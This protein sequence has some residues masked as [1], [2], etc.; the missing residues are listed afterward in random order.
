MPSP[1]PLV[2]R[3]VSWTRADGLLREPALAAAGVPH[4]F[5]LRELGD[6]SSPARR[7][8][9]CRR[10]GLACGP[11]VFA[12]QE[13]GARIREAE[14][15]SGPGARRAVDAEGDGWV[16]RA[17]GAPVGVFSADCLPVLLWSEDFRVVGA[18]HAGWRGLASGML[19]SAVA[20]L[21]APARRLGAAVGPHVE[22]RCY[23]VGADVAARFDPASVLREDGR[24]F[25]DLA[26]EAALRLTRAGVKADAVSV[27]DACTACRT[28]ECFSFRREKGT[29][30]PGAKVPSHL[31]FIAL[32]A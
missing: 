32:P 7:A 25:L 19:E 24:I 16:S 8:D 3:S 5:T 17:G 2:A 20:R 18:F 31:T 10:A 11:A 14:A 9:A 13:H 6:M 22:A 26:A 28:E 27:S 12:R 23:E 4:G 21:G 29:L 1:E 15:W 30:A